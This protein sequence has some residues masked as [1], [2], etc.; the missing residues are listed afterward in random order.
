M[1]H[2]SFI[3][4]EHTEPAKGMTHSCCGLLSPVHNI[5]SV[6][7]ECQSFYAG[8]C[9]L[10]KV[11]KDPNS[12]PSSMSSST[13]QLEKICVSCGSDNQHSKSTFSR[14]SMFC[15]SLYLSSSSSSENQQRLGNLPFLPHPSSQN[16]PSCAVQH[17]KHPLI[18]SDTNSLSEGNSEE[19]IRDFLNPTGYIL[20]GSAHGISCSSNSLALTEQLDLHFLS[21]ELHIAIGSNVENPRLDEIYE[22][23][24]D[25]R[26]PVVGLASNQN[27]DSVTPA[28]DTLP[29]QNSSILPAANKPRMRWT[30]EVHDCFLEAVNKLDGA[31]KATPKAVLKVMNVEGLTIYHV[32]SHLQKYRLAK[33][34]PERKEDKKSSGSEERRV[35]LSSNESDGRRKGSS[36]FTEALCMQMEVQKQLHEQLEVFAEWLSVPLEECKL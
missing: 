36:Q 15:T 16:Q 17:A 8:E 23:P 6:E 31:E 5:S 25:L 9:S 27:D 34:M 32:K 26:K 12:L 2:R 33:Y 1:N 7:A 22:A 20:D 29:S 19:V 4:P 10:S 21:D 13:L 3:F 28:I 18:F 11:C 35:A 30:P 24:E 14:S